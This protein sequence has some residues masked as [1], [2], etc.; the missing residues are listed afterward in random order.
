MTETKWGNKYMK[1]EDRTEEVCVTMACKRFNSCRR[2][3]INNKGTHYVRSYG[4]EGKG[5]MDSSG[6]RAES[7]CGPAGG[8]KLFEP[9]KQEEKE[10]NK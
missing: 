9:V 8:Y 4:T 10:Q 6:I 2:S 5:T 1:E 7:L 3:V